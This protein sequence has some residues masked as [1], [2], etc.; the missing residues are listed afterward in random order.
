M[1]EGFLHRSR[2]LDLARAEALARQL[3]VAIE[4]DD[5]DYLSG[6]ASIFGAVERLRHAAEREP[7]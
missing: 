3:L 7:D 1:L 4:R 2:G 5:P 6:S